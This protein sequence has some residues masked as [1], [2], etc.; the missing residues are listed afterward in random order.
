MK[1]TSS[2]EWNNQA[3]EAFWDL[4]RMLSTAPILVVPANKEPQLLYITATSW[5]VTTVLVVERPEEGNIQSAQHPVYYLSE[6][7]SAS[8]KNYPHYQKMCYGVYLTAKKMKQYFQKHVITVALDDFLAD[9]TNTQYLPPLPD[10]TH[11]RMRFDSSKMRSGLGAGIIHFASNNAAEYEALVH[12][13]RLAKE[14]DVRRILC[15]GDSDLVV[16]QPSGNFDDCEFRHV[17]CAENEAADTLDKIGSTRQAIPSGVS[18]EHLCKPSALML[19]TTSHTAEVS[20]LKRRLERADEEL[21]RADKQLEDKQGD[22]SEVE[23]LKNAPAE[24]QKKAEEERAARQKHESTVEVVQQELKDAISKCESL[25]CKVADRDSELAKALQSA[26]EA[27]VEAKGALREIQERCVEQD[28]G[29]EILLNIH[30]GEC[31]HHAASKSLVAKAFCNGFYWPTALKDAGRSSS[32]GL[33][34]VGPFKTARGGMMHL[35]VAVDKFTKWIEARPIKQHDGPTTVR[36]VKDI[37]VR[38]GVSHSIITDNGTNFAKGALVQYCSVSGNRLDLASVAHPQS[39]AQ[40]EQANGLILSGISWLDELLAVL[41]SLRT[42]PNR[43][44]GFTPFFLIYGAE[45][46]IPTDIEFDSPRVTMYTEAQAKEARED[47]ISLLEEAHLLALSR[48]TIYQQSLRH[49]HNK[50]IKPLAFREGDLVLRLV[51]QQAGQHKLA[52]PWEGPFI[53]SKAPCD[54][55][56]YYLI[57]ARKPNKCKRDTASKETS[58]PWNAELLHP[59]YS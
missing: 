8:K 29:I 10:S 2:F 27:R 43:S 53:F 26:Q 17:S 1:K 18:L 42:T 59:F 46:V 15:Y 9:W 12:G 48:S 31:G 44:T 40:V 58:W 54:R 3:D 47:D 4:K 14:L 25:E 49:H 51:Q 34:M 20:K 33:D 56:A 39:N 5:T 22:A 6:V 38:Y 36:F 13:L 57:D 41:W 11:W 30:K 23:S 21:I 45:S 55:N 16:Q 28:K 7:L 24:A 37:M 19:A 50:K 32:S 52:S 35:L